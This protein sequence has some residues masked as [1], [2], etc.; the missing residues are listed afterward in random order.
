MFEFCA[1]W[2]AG[3][4]SRTI[5]RHFAY[6]ISLRV[7][8]AYFFLDR[9]ARQAVMDNLRQVYRFKGQS[10]SEREIHLSAR[11]TFQYFGKYLVDFFRFSQLS[12]EKI[13][14][15][16]RIEHPEY[17]DE[18]KRA[19]KG[20]I[21]VTAHLGNWE[22]GGAVMA[23]LGNPLSVVVLRQ[24]SRKLNDFFQKHRRQRG[25]TI[26]PLGQAAKV[27]ITTLRKKGFVALLADRDYSRRTDLVML[28]GQRAC[29]PRGPA[30][31]AHATGAPILPA[32][33]LRQ[34][35][36]TFLLRL[37]PPI[38]AGSG[39]SREDIQGQLCRVLEDAVARSPEQ[40]FMFEKVWSGQAYGQSARERVASSCAGEQEDVA[41]GS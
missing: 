41:S 11:Q 17:I 26:V 7:S 8:D 30:W 25:M 14:L 31:M 38:L 32:F 20:V 10:V 3:F 9:V 36:D 4:V 13:R 28:C 21:M 29:L 27:L 35:D 37:Y 40:W 22:L 2:L 6:W 15:L 5:P 18:A 16:V 23:G 19:D 34:P 1:Y 12:E 39:S 33:M 24:R